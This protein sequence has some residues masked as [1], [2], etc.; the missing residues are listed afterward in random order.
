MSYFLSIF[1][2]QPTPILTLNLKPQAPIEIHFIFDP[3][4]LINHIIDT[5]TNATLMM[6]LNKPN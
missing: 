1:K 5:Q 4:L 6:D 3:K 2:I